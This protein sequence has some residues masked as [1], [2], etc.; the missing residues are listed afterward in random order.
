[1]LKLVSP[2][3]H[4]SLTILSW[5]VLEYSNRMGFMLVASDA[6]VPAHWMQ[7]RTPWFT[8]ALA[9]ADDGCRDRD[10]VDPKM[11]LDDSEPFSADPGSFSR[12]QLNKHGEGYADIILK[13][14]GYDCTYHTNQQGVC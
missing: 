8:E 6:E 4:H 11:N 12:H 14:H 10:P 7:T 9:K 3:F 1:M 5:K 13:P 2:R